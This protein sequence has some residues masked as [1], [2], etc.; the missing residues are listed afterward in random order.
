MSLKVV[1]AGLEFLLTELVANWGVLTVHLFQNNKVPAD[2]DGVGDYTEATFSGYNAQNASG[3]SAPTLQPDGVHFQ[4]QATAMIFTHNGGGTSN[5]VWGYYVTNSGGVLLWAEQ[6][7]SPPIFMS[8]TGDFISL[9]P[10][11]QDRSEF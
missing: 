6:F 3:W 2:G 1:R 8:V 7:T 10:T 9:V 11:F 5:N 4:T